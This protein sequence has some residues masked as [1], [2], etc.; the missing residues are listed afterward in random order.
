MEKSFGTG[1]RTR[2]SILCRLILKIFM[3]MLVFIK[4]KQGYY[5]ST[6]V[7]IFAIG[8]LHSVD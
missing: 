4:K 1:M 8:R 3:F 2:K 7:K 6:A 5:I